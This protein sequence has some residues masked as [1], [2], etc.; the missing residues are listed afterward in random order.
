LRTTYNLDEVFL[1]VDDDD[2]KQKL[3]NYQKCNV[4]L[5]KNAL[6]VDH[7][8]L[9][10]QG[11]GAVR[12]GQWARALCINENL[13]IGTIF[14][15]LEKAEKRGW[16]VIV[17]NPNLNEFP[18]SEPQVLRKS[19]LT[20]QKQLPPRI[21][22]KKIEGNRNYEEH[23]EYVWKHFVSCSKASTITVVA[24]SRGGDGILCTLR[25]HTQEFYKRVAAIAFT[26]SVHSVNTKE[27][28]EVVKYLKYRTKNWV[29]SKLPLGTFVREPFNDCTCVSA[30][31]DAHEYT[32]GTAI[33]DVFR[34][35]DENAGKFPKKI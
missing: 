27:S 25:N 26:D 9:L 21:N 18:Q 20:Q 6:Q 32:S 34:F 28:T 30:G 12:A 14:P 5:S 31:H 33:E 19:F 35:I 10:I 3:Q 7:L 13:N 15:Y 8:L 11:A 24:H 23:N 1:P 22:Y 29:T 17:F 4:F 16:G 2:T